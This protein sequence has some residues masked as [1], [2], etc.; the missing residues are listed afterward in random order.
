MINQTLFAPKL[1][2]SARTTHLQS[3]TDPAPHKYWPL[4]AVLCAWTIIY[5]D[6]A[7]PAPTSFPSP[8]QSAAA[9]RD[10]LNADEDT[11]CHYCWGVEFCEPGMGSVVR[12][13]S[14]C[15]SNVSSQCRRRGT[16]CL[17]QQ[18]HHL[19]D[20]FLYPEWLCGEC[21]YRCYGSNERQ[22][23]MLRYLPLRPLVPPPSLCWLPSLGA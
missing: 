10:L 11:C 14:L 6:E 20:K 18:F 23:C 9:R 2:T 13:D 16:L 8:L 15:E 17:F 3:H 5:V 19:L 7:P 4:Q 22:G 12:L 1:I 21:V